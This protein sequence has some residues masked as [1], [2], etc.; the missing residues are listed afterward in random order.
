MG[1]IE[2]RRLRCAGREEREAKREIGRDVC[3]RE[4]RRAR[5]RD[6]QAGEDAAE[7][8]MGAIYAVV[9][10]FQYRVAQSSTKQTDLPCP[11]EAFGW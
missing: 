10:A 8:Y 7:I 5:D 2:V 1:R 9:H 3:W 6:G 11:G 4:K